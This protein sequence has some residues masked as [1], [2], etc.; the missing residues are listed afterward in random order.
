MYSWEREREREREKTRQKHTSQRRFLDCYGLAS[1]VVRCALCVV[2]HSLTSSSQELLANLYQIW[3]V[4][5]PPTPRGGNFGVNSVKLIYFF[6]NLLLYL[7]AW[8][9]QNKCIVI[10]TREGSTKIVNFMTPGAEVL[11]LGRGHI[12][13]IVKLHYYFKHLL[14]YSQA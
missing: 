3:Y 14:L 12:S 10:M 1:V 4:A 11:L 2:R 6:K 7:G 9:R 5:W 13:H 8:F